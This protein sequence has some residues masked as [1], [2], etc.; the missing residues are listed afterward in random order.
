MSLLRRVLT[1]GI[2]R[3]VLP[4]PGK[5]FVFLYHDISDPDAPQHSELYSTRVRRFR[6][7][8]EFLAKYF[9]L[10]PL[11]EIVS[12]APGGRNRL[13]SLT[14]DDGFLSVR[15]EAYPYLSSRGIPFAVFVNRAAVENNRLFY[16]AETPD[17]NR[18]YDRK[19]FLDEDD[20][21]YLAGHG[22]RIGSHSS[23]HRVLS[24]C[25]E[26]EE[27]REE[28]LGNKLYVEG[29]VGGQ[30]KHLALPFGKREHYDERVLE[31]CRRAGHEFIFSTNPTFFG[32]S[33][34]CYRRRLIPRIAFTNQTLA[35]MTFMI[36]RPLLKTIDI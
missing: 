35:E 10:V 20:V 27:L 15:E 21:K 13:A 30:V 36:N 29:L 16:G 22:V 2:S 4:G 9:K 14:F 34:P 26:E 12:D 18:S 32:L 5:R 3:T 23:T 28:V 11:D 24:E 33:S 17:I 6:E 8:V 7:Q 1:K 25:G 31:Y 19:V